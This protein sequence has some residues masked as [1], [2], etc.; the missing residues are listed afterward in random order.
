M[1]KIS[2]RMTRFIGGLVIFLLCG[3]VALGLA[4]NVSTDVTSSDSHAFE[5]A[6]GLKTPAGRMAYDDEIALIKSVQQ[7]VLTRVPVG[8]PIPDFQ[9]REPADL[10][11]LGTGLCYDRARTYDK[12]YTWLGFEA[13]HVYILYP[14]HPVTGEALSFVRAMLTYRTGSHA[15][16]EVKTSRGWLVVD[17]NSAW[18]S[19]ADDGSPVDADH[20]AR[21]SARLPGIPAYF[22]RPFWA[23]RGLYSRRGQLYKPFL[24]Y[25]DVNWRDFARWATR[26]DS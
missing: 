8:E 20:L 26:L 19:V 4:T 10:L 22:N 14:E 7:R 9:E 24:P 15:V 6:L 23:L 2:F 25:P 16:T 11:Q 12:A 5:N 21:E 17:S 18:V 3:N 13:R 1:K